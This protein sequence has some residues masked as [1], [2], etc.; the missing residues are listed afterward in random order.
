MYHVL[1]CKQEGIL[2]NIVHAI[3]NYRVYSDTCMLHALGVIHSNDSVAVLLV[4][5]VRTVAVLLVSELDS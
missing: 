5:E 1:T 4:S 3:L 2:N